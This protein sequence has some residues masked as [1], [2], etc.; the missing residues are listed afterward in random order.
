MTLVKIIE[1]DARLLSTHTYLYYIP[2]N[3]NPFLAKESL[4]GLLKLGIIIFIIKIRW[5]HKITSVVIF[6]AELKV[7]ILKRCFTAKIFSSFSLNPCRLFF[8]FEQRAY[9]HIELTKAKKINKFNWM[10]DDITI[11]KI[12][13][14]LE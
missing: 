6:S 11:E 8:L 10:P 7:P 13:K 12:S 14:F 5:Y 1:K 4:K 2:W 9:L 3:W